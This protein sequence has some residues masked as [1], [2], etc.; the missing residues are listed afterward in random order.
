MALTP[1]QRTNI[2]SR[3]VTFATDNAPAFGDPDEWA[4]AQ[5]IMFDRFRA[6]PSFRWYY[7]LRMVPFLDVLL[8]ARVTAA[9]RTAIDNHIAGL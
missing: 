2:R 9:L 6:D 3:L 1:A 8:G 4:D 7:A 5:L